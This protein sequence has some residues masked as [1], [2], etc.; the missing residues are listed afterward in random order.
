MRSVRCGGC[1]SGAG[2]ESQGELLGAEL[3]PPG[4]DEDHITRV[5]FRRAQSFLDEIRGNPESGIKALETEKLGMSASTPRQRKG[6]T[7]S[8][9]AH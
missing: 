1:G 8:T 6:S 4:P 5:D 9:P 7:V 3:R 2:R